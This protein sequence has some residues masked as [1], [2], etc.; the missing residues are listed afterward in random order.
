MIWQHHTRVL[1]DPICTRGPDIAVQSANY[2]H[3]PILIIPLLENDI[4]DQLDQRQY[5]FFILQ[6][7]V[8]RIPRM[9]FFRPSFLGTIPKPFSPKTTPPPR[10]NYIN[11]LLGSIHQWM[12]EFSPNQQTSW[13]QKFANW[14]LR[15]GTEGVVFSPNSWC[16]NVS[17][18][19]IKYFPFNCHELWYRFVCKQSFPCGV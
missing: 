7:L 18:S 2:V 11:Y 3:L 14:D 15:T 19:P 10:D 8:T 6:L 9:Y 16:S 1:C 5:F 4:D 13:A 12:Q 17:N